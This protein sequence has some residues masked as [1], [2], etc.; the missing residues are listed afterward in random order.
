[1]A[2]CS[3]FR[4]CCFRQQ[5]A[6]EDTESSEDYPKACASDMDD[7]IDE[8]FLSTGTNVPSAEF[9]SIDDN[10]PTCE[11][12]SVAGIVVEVVWGTAVEDVG[13]EAPEDS[14]ENESVR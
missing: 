6:S 2:A 8:E 10:I 4:K 13:D 5:T 14:G 1:M 7:D 3:C 9:I 12:Q 11:P